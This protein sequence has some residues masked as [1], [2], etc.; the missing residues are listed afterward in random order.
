[1][2]AAV[3]GGVMLGAA[4][5]LVFV[6]L[7]RV[8]GVTGMIAGAW[9]AA[10]NGWQW[11]A[12]FLAGLVVAG[13]IGRALSPASVPGLSAPLGLA[14]A[15]GALVGFGARYGGGCTSG[16]GVCGVGR[17]SPRS[18]VGCATFMAVAMIVVFAL[19]QGGVR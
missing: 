3:I 19:R 12:A 9:P 6:L 2:A 16:H 13:A 14:I 8:S 17:L 18:I 10:R 5:G 4:S 15:S 1:M 7:G 11:P